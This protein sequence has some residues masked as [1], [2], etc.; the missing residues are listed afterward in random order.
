MKITEIPLE[1]VDSSS[2]DSVLRAHLE[3]MQ[4]GGGMVWMIPIQWRFVSLS[5]SFLE[6]VFIQMPCV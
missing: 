3:Q 4:F 5:C 6:G 2:L 1:D